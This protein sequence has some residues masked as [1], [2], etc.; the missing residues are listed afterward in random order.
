MVVSKK[1]G[2]PSHLIAS[3]LTAALA[4]PA[5]APVAFAQNKQPTA[6]GKAFT[7]SIRGLG[8]TDC[9]LPRCASFAST[10]GVNLP[11]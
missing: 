6:S 4:L 5:V 8:S 7:S 1:A 9:T 2:M 11:S 3:L 10:D